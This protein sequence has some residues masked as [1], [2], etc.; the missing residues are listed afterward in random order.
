[1][2][3]HLTERVL[4]EQ[5][6]A[7]LLGRVVFLQHCALEWNHDVIICRVVDPTNVASTCTDPLRKLPGCPASCTQGYFFSLNICTKG[8]MC[9]TGRTR[10]HADL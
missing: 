7:A 1:M 4:H 9:T 10:R 2:L 8:I 5:Q 3:V 6:V